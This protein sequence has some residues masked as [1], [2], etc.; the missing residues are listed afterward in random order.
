M[1]GHYE[2]SM[3]ATRA[4]GSRGK[5]SGESHW[6]SSKLVL[7]QKEGAEVQEADKEIK[8]PQPEEG[9]VG[10]ECGVEC[11]GAPSLHKEF[12]A[13]IASRQNS[14]DLIPEVDGEDL[15]SPG[16][17][18]RGQKSAGLSSLQSK[19]KLGAEKGLLGFQKVGE[20]GAKLG[21]S[22]TAQRARIS[23]EATPD[24][25]SDDA[26]GTAEA[27]EKPGE[28]TKSGTR[29][30]RGKGR[31]EVKRFELFLGMKA[32]VVELPPS[33]PIP[34]SAMGFSAT[35][36]TAA[37][38]QGKRGG[39]QEQTAASGPTANAF[40]R[41]K[42]SGPVGD[43]VLEDA[44]VKAASLSEG[45]EAHPREEFARKVKG[46][47]SRLFK[48][49]STSDSHREILPRFLEPEQPKPQTPD[50]V[51]EPGQAPVVLD[52]MDPLRLAG[53]EVGDAPEIGLPTEVES[54]I[55]MVDSVN[56]LTAGP[57]PEGQGDAV[58]VP[59]SFEERAEA[60]SFEARAGA[61]SP[62]TESLETES[63]EARAGVESVLPAEETAAEQPVAGS[64]LRTNEAPPLDQ[65]AE[66][67][68]SSNETLVGNVERV[69]GAPDEPVSAVPIDSPTPTDD[70]V[71]L[72]ALAETLCDL[73]LEDR[74]LLKEERAEL[75]EVAEPSFPHWLAGPSS[76]D[77]LLVDA[78]ASAARIWEGTGT[79]KESGDGV[80]RSQPN[81]P[82]PGSGES[83][84]KSG[85]AT[86]QGTPGAPFGNGNGAIAS[87]ARVFVDLRS[88]SGNGIPKVDTGPSSGK[89]TLPD[90]QA[91]GRPKSI[92]RPEK[93]PPD[94]HPTPTIDP[95]LGLAAGAPSSADTEGGDL[96]ATGHVQKERRTSGFV[97]LVSWSKWEDPQAKPEAAPKLELQYPERSTFADIVEGDKRVLA[98]ALAYGRWWMRSWRVP[99][100]HAY[101]P[102]VIGG[103][104]ARRPHLVVGRLLQ[105]AA[106][107]VAAGVPSLVDLAKTRDASDAFGRPDGSERRAAVRQ[108]ALRL[109]T[110]LV[111]LG[112]TF[113]KAAQS[114]SARPDVVGEETA[115]VL[116]E[117]QDR[118]PP[119]S[120]SAA[121]AVIERE[122]GRPLAD[123]F[124][125]LS[126]EPVAAASFG[127]VYKGRTKAGE[128][129][130]VKVQRPG[131]LRSVALDIHILR[132][133]LQGVRKVASINSDL[134]L[135]ADE[136]GC[137]LYGELDYRAEA[138]NAE[139]FATSQRHLPF[140]AVPRVLHDFTARRVLTMEW[141]EGDRPVDLLAAA[142]ARSLS[143][144]SSEAQT[145]LLSLVSMG[146]ESSLV[147]LLETG[148][149]HSDPH[150]GN[151]LLQADG[152]LVYLD[153]GLITRIMPQHRAAMLAAIAH[154]VNAEWA[155][156]TDDL[157]ALDVLKPSNDRGKVA[158]ALAAAFTGGAQP[159]I[160]GSGVPRV[161]FGQVASK[162]WAIALRFRFKL[163]PYF[164]LVLRNLA[165]LEG[166]GL[167]VDPSF[168]VFASAYPHV[169]RRL[170]T[171]N[172]P[173][174]RRVL[175]TLLTDGQGG[176][177]WDRVAALAAGTS[178]TEPTKLVASTGAAGDHQERASRAAGIILGSSG[179]GVRRVLLGMDLVRFAAGFSSASAA[180]VRAVLAAAAADAIDRTLFEAPTDTHLRVSSSETLSGS[181]THCS[182]TR[183]AAFS[184]A[185]TV[186][187][188]VAISDPIL[189]T[190]LATFV[191]YSP[192]SRRTERAVTKETERRVLLKRA[193]LLLKL[194]ASKPPQA[195]AA[196]A[197]LFWTAL[198]LAVAVLR[199]LS[200]RVWRRVSAAVGLGYRRIEADSVQV[201]GS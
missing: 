165:S 36:K 61:L 94:P 105:I 158:R 87:G 170:L 104:F 129:V 30:I 24:N 55:P 20:N 8:V 31:A 28:F 69:A 178:G 112:P 155:A 159:L 149:M 60:G 173:T 3:G 74:I 39:A 17:L 197:R 106:A 116:A 183:S 195:L 168:K 144:G 134:R 161:R 137:G 131:V 143:A 135:L 34:L 35:P 162:L 102:E 118:L 200:V 172:T 103:Y 179:A 79:S 133:L 29:I 142:D 43:K 97:N 130:A 140:V 108:S 53:G 85:A 13:F 151:L 99:L 11:I 21:V 96:K 9:E 89:D 7:T 66:E 22:G 76:R 41:K 45:P 65:A 52:A 62:S 185:A 139:L 46:F 58:V 6:T 59:S 138:A 193:W 187:Q 75:G 177:R 136:L 107:T 201:R 40:K 199:G 18:G 121:M 124:A 95:S 166:I 163:P 26:S 122:L 77:A 188:I 127:Q 181:Q 115:A 64:S 123:L 156:L 54:V 2:E 63:P 141:I 50:P 117:L 182:P 10:A 194:I 25:P 192:S 119:F 148:V 174:T 100:Q 56:V 126:D 169:V 110:A 152:K 113:I 80:G 44:S 73:D 186:S 160:T 5:A 27:A 68:A 120:S 51:L 38:K 176:V 86:S 14:G 91:N 57:L 71:Q 19:K 72:A 47:A 16:G 82:T 109:K 154:L 88:A 132:S 157:D 1:E 191:V 93:P 128:A 78:E 125:E 171:E 101:E 33:E 12:G 4:E 92:S 37:R 90:R 184:P 49:V 70:K 150:P 48:A 167:T 196:R 190:G 111:G 83:D 180:P 23:M 153:F 146:I 147:Q 98:S 15:D 198:L 114:L 67:L 189:T 175:R 81:G 84:A 42:V 32:P 164:T 145:K